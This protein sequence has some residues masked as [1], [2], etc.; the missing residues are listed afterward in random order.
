MQ[1]RIQ[2][3]TQPITQTTHTPPLKH[4]AIIM[5]G[6]GRWAKKQHKPRIFGHKNGVKAVR[7]AVEKS[8]QL[9]LQSLTLFAFSSEN[10]HRPKLEV[11]LLFSLFLTALKSEVKKLATHNI[12]LKFIGDMSIFPEKIQHLATQAVADLSHNTGLEL[13][14]AANYGGK[15]DITQAANAAMRAAL[16]N[17]REISPQDITSQDITD[18]LSIDYDI[19]LV[20]RTSGEQRISNFLLWQC[21]YS[22]FYFTDVLWPDFDEIEFDKA[23]AEF[24]HRQR[25]FGK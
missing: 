25:R 1:N 16:N 13:I 3:I 18:N 9:G 2:P 21:A 19:D 11:D 8:A 4:L 6:N 17:N 15:W 10:I 22:E 7:I 20:I 5:D 24:E 23:I 14:I 12:R